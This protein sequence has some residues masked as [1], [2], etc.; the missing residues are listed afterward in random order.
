MCEC[1]TDSLAFL[2]IRWKEM[3]YRVAPL[4]FLYV[5]AQGWELTICLLKR[6]QKKQAN[7]DVSG[8]PSAQKLVKNIGNCAVLRVECP[9]LVHAGIEIHPW[10]P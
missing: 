7:S 5:L 1:A 6:S 8:R 3:Q 2:C 9:Y 10:A 4:S